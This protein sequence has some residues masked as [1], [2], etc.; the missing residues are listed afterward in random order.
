L[1]IHA[2]QPVRGNSMSPKT[3][4]KSRY[5]PQCSAQ[6]TVKSSGGIYGNALICESCHFMA[7]WRWCTKTPGAEKTLSG[8]LVKDV[9]AKAV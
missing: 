1:V 5:C 8:E 2:S 7:P 3:E 4:S 6:V 9:L